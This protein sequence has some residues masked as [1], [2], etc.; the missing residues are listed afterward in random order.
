MFQIKRK[1]TEDGAWLYEDPAEHTFIFVALLTYGFDIAEFDSF[2]ESIANSPRGQ[3]LFEWRQNALEADR[4]SNYLALEGWLNAL[5][6]SWYEAKKSEFLRPLAIKGKKAEE[7]VGKGGQKRAEKYKDIG[8]LAY[9]L[10][11][12]GKYASR[13]NATTNIKSEVINY[14]ASKGVR[15][16]EHQAQETIN[17][18][19]KERGYDP[20]ASKKGVPAS[21]NGA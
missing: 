21:S 4:T 18:W 5:N 2:L 11:Q 20:S 13:N 1:K 9:K 8:D 12:K 19:L 14:A 6:I 17:G 10:A 15:L 16:S 3:E 7:S